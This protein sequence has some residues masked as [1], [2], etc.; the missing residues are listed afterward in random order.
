MIKFDFKVSERFK[1]N[2]E[3]K[4]SLQTI[5]G[6]KDLFLFFLIS[7]LNSKFPAPDKT[8]QGAKARALG[9]FLD[10]VDLAT[11]TLIELDKAELDLLKELFL[12]DDVKVPPQLTQVYI[13]YIKAVE[14]AIASEKE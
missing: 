2:E 14:Q 10:K 8:P 13:Y 6:H 4:R 3:Q 9:R 7:F 1:M 5:E 12:S 11:E